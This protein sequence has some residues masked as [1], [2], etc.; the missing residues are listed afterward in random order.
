MFCKILVLE[1]S[2]EVGIFDAM[3]GPIFVIILFG[4][5]FDCS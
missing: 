5:S 4:Y 1:F 2:C 3:V